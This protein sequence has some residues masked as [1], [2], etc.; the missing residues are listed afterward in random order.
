MPWIQ[1]SF[2]PSPQN[3]KDFV[4]HIAKIAADALGLNASEVVVLFSEATV[5]DPGGAVVSIS[6]RNRGDLQEAAL[7]QVLRDEIAQIT[8]IP[9]ELVAIVRL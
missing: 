8:G 9:Q 4:S 3:P 1:V 7:G 2:G 5:S 6:G